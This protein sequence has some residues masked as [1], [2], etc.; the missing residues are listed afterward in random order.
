M[1]SSARGHTTALTPVATKSLQEGISVDG[2]RWHLC[3]PPR[4]TRSRAA[5]ACLSSSSRPR[6]PINHE[7]TWQLAWQ[8]LASTVRSLLRH[9]CVVRYSL[10]CCRDGSSLANPLE[11]NHNKRLE[12]CPA[13]PL[14]RVVSACPSEVLAA[15]TSHPPT[16]LASVR[17]ASLNT[18]LPPTWA[19]RGTIS[20]YSATAKHT[21]SGMG[22]TDYAIPLHSNHLTRL[23]SFSEKK[24]PCRLT[25][26]SLILYSL[27]RSASSHQFGVRRPLL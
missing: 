13:R 4:L 2:Y 12:T 10:L 8:S 16:W 20:R 14:L 6:W 1:F 26:H 27:R 3:W 11:P 17:V 25:P 9:T 5:P 24:P 21:R 22:V 15:V 23:D 7:P 19:V 18:A